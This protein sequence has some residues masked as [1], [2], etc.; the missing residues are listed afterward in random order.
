MLNKAAL[1]YEYFQ[2]QLLVALGDEQCSSCQQVGSGSCV[3]IYNWML[4]IIVTVCT[5][6]NYTIIMG[7][8]LKEYF[9]ES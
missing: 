7:K 8:L 2:H 3:V 5:K 9:T 4:C 6:M 1:L